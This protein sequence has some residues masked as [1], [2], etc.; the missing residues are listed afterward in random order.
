[1]AESTCS[2]RLSALAAQGNSWAERFDGEIQ[3]AQR[4]AQIHPDWAQGWDALIGQACQTV[5][6]VVAAGRLDQLGQAVEQAEATLAPIAERAKQFTVY[7]VGHAHIDMNW[8]WS[9]PETVA[10]TH[11][12][13]T[14][15]LKLMEEFPEFCFSQSQASVYAILRDYAPELLAPIRRRIEEGR[16]EVTATQWVEGD[17][18][19]ASGESL[20]R[21][22]LYTRRF[23]RDLFSLSPE[24][25]QLDWEPDMFGHAHTIPTILNR[26]GVTRYYMCRSGQPAKPP[27]Y[28]WQGPDG[29]RVLVVR[30]N[31]WYNGE[32]TTDILHQLLDGHQATGLMG[33]M[34]VY[35]VGDHGGGPTRRDLRRAVAMDA[36]PVFPHVKFATTKP[37][38]EL[39]EANAE[40]LPVLDGEINFEFTGCYTTQTLIKKANRFGENF[41]VEAELAASLAWRALGRPYPAEEIRTAWVDT[42]FGQFHDIL[43]GSGVHWT[44]EYQSGLFQKVSAITNMIKSRSLRALAGA[45]DTG[46]AKSDLP[47]I[48]PAQESIAM[49][50]GVGY[51]TMTGGLSAASHV[52]DGPRPFVVFNPTPWAR[53]EVVEA[54]VWDAGTGVNPGDVQYKNFTVRTPDGR[55]VPAQRLAAGHYWGH[56][57]ARLALPIRVEPL[58][59]AACVIEEGS[60]EAPDE[61]VWVGENPARVEPHF[62]SN[63]VFEND[64]LRVEF[65]QA[66]GGVRSLVDKATGRDLATPADPLGT[67]EFILERPRNMTAWLIA[68]AL[69]RYRPEIKSVQ[70][71][72]RGPYVATL[73]A[74]ATVESSEVTV[75]YTLRAGSDRLEIAIQTRWLEQGR[76]DKGTPQLR[77]RFPLAIEQATGRYEI[78][79]GSIERDLNQGQELPALRWADIRGTQD[80]QPAGLTLTNDSKYGHSLDGSVLALTLIRSSYD[81]DPLPEIGEH[82]VHLAVR[83]R[84]SDLPVD[85]L[86]AAGAAVNHPLQ[87]ISTDAHD[88]TLPT[89]AAGV[90][91]EPANVVLSSIRKAHDEDAL[92]LHLYDTA[93]Q[94]TRATVRFGELLGRPDKATEVDLLERMKDDCTAAVDGEA[95]SVTVPA[96]GITAVMVYFRA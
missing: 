92:I 28:W 53:Q 33:W 69:R 25:C 5:D 77:M 3:F 95:V 13:F 32:I 83:A 23:M 65:D 58:G 44:R 8:M 88:G 39:I 40:S 24:D 27:V 70:V 29:S 26:G 19:I 18:N 56:N 59:Y 16:W 86:V 79:F 72:N 82:E 96:H 2:E 41:S 57:F 61:K 76:P 80:G 7:C 37:F 45:V 85:A 15:V 4:L 31:R 6:Q 11:D 94:Q 78:P 71:S 12:T 49:G 73:V 46:F 60:A 75:S 21:H 38:F 89:A 67:L 36:W 17:K 20:A 43:P 54:M 68:P 93:G 81:P 35:G 34:K 87:V 64:R 74:K 90:T 42:L 9:W 10:V 1:M 91:V 63:P 84:G 50:A 62:D 47:E 52:T 55:T 22:M 14:T 30:E 48:P 51:G 66:T